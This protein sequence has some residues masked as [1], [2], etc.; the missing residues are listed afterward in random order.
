VG[1]GDCGATLAKGAAAVQQQLGTLPL[2]DAG[3]AA[4]V[5]GR[6]VGRSMGGTSW[7]VVSG[8]GAGGV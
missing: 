1:D 2:D 6:V 5:L 3:T 4:V 7:A 8:L